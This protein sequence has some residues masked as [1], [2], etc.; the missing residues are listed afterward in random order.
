MGWRRRGPGRDVWK[1]SLPEEA[2]PGVPEPNPD[3]GPPRFQRSSSFAWADGFQEV[4]EVPGLGG[5]VLTLSRLPGDSL[6]RALC[7]RE[8]A[9]TA[10]LRTCTRLCVSKRVL[11]RACLPVC[12][13]LHRRVRLSYV[14]RPSRAGADSRARGLSGPSVHAHRGC[15]SCPRSRGTDSMS[16]CRKFI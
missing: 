13:R 11:G 9:F 2:S 1:G 12:V 10:R 15:V 6:H 7:T 8:L 4:Q 14:T 3:P 16:F 5:S